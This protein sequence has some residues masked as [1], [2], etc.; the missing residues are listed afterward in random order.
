MKKTIVYFLLLFLCN[1][2]SIGTE[3]YKK[4]L[5]L[6]EGE[7]KIESSPTGQG[8]ELVQLLGHFITNTSIKGLSTYTS[9]DIENYDYV[10]Y[11][12]FSP[13]YS[14]PYSFLKDIMNT[15]K[16][17]IWINYGIEQ[18]CRNEAFEKQYGFK[19]KR[20]EELS[21]FNFVKS[22]GYKFEKGSPEINYIDIKNYKNIEIWATAISSK[23]G[24]E[25]PYMVKSG[26]LTY[27]ADLPFLGATENDRY[28]FFSDKLH[29]ILN[30]KHQV[31]HTAIIRIEDVT[32]LHNPNT[33]REIADILSAKGIP[34]LVGVVPI[35]VNPVED[36]RVRLTDKP[37]LVD[38]LKYMVQ[39][40]GS[41]VMHGVTH[42]Y[43]GISTNDFEFWDGSVQRPINEEN[44]DDITRKIQMGIDEFVKNGLY[45]IA[46]E[47]PHYTASIMTY[48]VV[49]KFFSTAVEQRM[50]NEN[51]DYG[52][53]FPYIIQK[54][55]YGQKIYPENL[56]YV[57]FS[58]IADSGKAAVQK[59]L[60]GASSIHQVRDGV[61]SCFFHP[62]LNLELLKELINGLSAEGY[63]F[64][65]INSSTNF[66]KTNDKVILTGSQS[67]SL[68]IDN[69]FLQEIYYDGSGNIFKKKSSQERIIGRITKDIYLEPG[70][71][72]V[73]EA[74][75]FH[76]IEPT[77][78]NKIHHFLRNTYADLFGSK[79]WQDMRVTL[80]WNHYSK[81]AAY[82]DQS[83]FASAFRSLNINVDTV[84]IDQN[85]ELKNCN[86][87]VIPY[88]SVDSLTYFDI[89]KIER[90]VKE[91]GNL[92]T[93]HKNRLIEKFG[94]KFLNAETK[95]HAIRDNYF[96]QELIQWKSSQLGY[97]FDYNNEDE[98]LCEDP[99]TGLAVSIGRNYGQGKFIYFNSAFDPSSQS[100]Y[101]YYPFI[102][103]HIKKFFQ[104]RPVFK[105]E[106]LSMYFD[107][108]LR[109]T[110]SI[111]N[112]IKIW[113]RQGIRIINV[114]GW[115]QYPKY[116]YDYTRLIKLA[117]ANGIL[118]YVWLEPPQVNQKF[119]EKHPEWREKN[120][121]NEDVRP[122]WRFPVALTDPNCL[123]EVIN[124]YIGILK[125]Y[126]WDGVNFAELYFDAGRGFMDPKMFTPLH[127][128]AC[129]EFKRKYGF[130][131][132]EIFNP[133]SQYY[134]K[135]NLTAKDDL[136][137]YRVSKINELHNVF[138]KIITDYAKTKEGFKVI[139]TFMDSHFSP[140]MKE[141]YGIN[142]DDICDLQKK[143]DIILQPEDPQ[144]KWSTDPSRYVSLGRFYAGRMKDS[145]KLLIDLNILPF[146]KKDDITP[147]PTLVQTGIES[148]QLIN[149]SL[150][151]ASN[152]TIYSEATCNPQDISFF[153]YASSE[154]VK[155]SFTDNGYKV[156]S[157]YSFEL[158]LPQ[159]IKMIEV[160]G[161]LIVGY[162]DNIFMIPAGEHLINCH[163]SNLPGFSTALLQPQILSFSGNLLSTDFDMRKIAIAYTSSARA[164]LSI[165][166]KPTKI[167][168]DDKDYPFKVLS[169]NDCFSVFLPCGNHKVEITTGDKF[170]YGLNITSLWSISAIAIYGT[171]AVLSLIIMFLFLKVV[172]R[173]LE[174]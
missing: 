3:V 43:R 148:Y 173:K 105:R 87:L 99:I 18:L 169:G 146:R 6:V 12:G 137:K 46:W 89:S 156:K 15:R 122:S 22:N 25:I 71:I 118:V 83:S 149:Y 8:R 103:E 2:V 163:V 35:Y 111:E 140:E 28:L 159:S 115:H 167:T 11:V 124:E 4:V 75:D 39:N 70:E 110:T 33:L 164:L 72:Y 132:K 49:S 80:M 63:S 36:R 174:N 131:I 160:D 158:Q 128:S 113:V 165:N 127:P 67:Y 136:V 81:G 114:A 19:V 69:A 66:V 82:N 155:Y 68:N 79:E 14:I 144:N 76:I 1:S 150:H 100:G 135:S 170:S 41:I 153:P 24:K 91:G 161:Q 51:Y 125:A 23:T 77:I 54:D 119:W 86:L 141:Y 133:S 94:I 31:S 166:N 59:I 44:A 93:D 143:Y 53:Y 55:I 5:V 101:S 112:L 73:A 97:K 121:K 27:V 109:Q 16:Q 88:A 95:M 104:L 38:A 58:T 154:N 9:H 107:P 52:Q 85:L 171:L 145:S 102:M 152:V 26:N 32:P 29:D 7:Y 130:S 90:F 13:W 162:R 138:L 96:P 48:K 20:F 37:E 65:D 61:A 172:R 47:T 45:P 157:A 139:V 92:I 147:F 117:H 50:V 60:K 123:K 151:A 57:P 134:W 62:F 116:N 98:V 56:G 10:F 108:G 34:F 129:N 64:L 74:N 30:E 126:D 78:S 106:N 120:F 21:Q 17:I 40:G 142:S 42:Q 84:F 168:V